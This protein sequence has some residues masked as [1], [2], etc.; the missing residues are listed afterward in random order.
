M[1]LTTARKSYKI[2]F[3]G[4]VLRK[5]VMAEAKQILQMQHVHSLTK[6]YVI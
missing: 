2:S 3:V 1:I 4:K 5:P 6:K